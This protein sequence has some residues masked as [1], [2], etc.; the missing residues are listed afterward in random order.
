MGKYLAFASEVADLIIVESYIVSEDHKQYFLNNFI[1]KVAKLL[2][3]KRYLFPSVMFSLWCTDRQNLHRFR[4]S[5]EHYQASI[6]LFERIVELSIMAIPRDILGPLLA[7]YH[8]VDDTRRFYS[9][10]DVSFLKLC[11]ES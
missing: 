1:P 11:D 6:E 10:R 4:Y 2:M 5:D 9:I 3:T 7:L 8:V